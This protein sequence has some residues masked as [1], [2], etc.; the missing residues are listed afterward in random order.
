MTP[1]YDEDGITIYHGDALTLFP[2]IADE[3]ISCVIL[4]P[5]YSFESISVRGRDDGAAGTSGAPTMLFHQTL[6]ETRRVL[7]DGGITP[8]LHQWRRGP[9]V[10]YLTALAGLRLSACVAWTRGRVGT[11]GLFRSSWDPILVGSKGSPNL[12]NRA[13]ISNVLHVEPLSG[14]PHPYAKPPGL[15]QHFTQRIP[16]GTVLDPFMGLGAAGVAAINEGHRFVGFE[17]DERYCEIAVQRLAQG[18]LVFGGD[19][20]VVELGES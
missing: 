12:R 15:W 16:F 2:D 18:V 7:K 10:A 6:L 19:E 4:D 14:E 3:S 8:I 5:P 20:R 11:G 17:A 1:Y 9:D 13:A